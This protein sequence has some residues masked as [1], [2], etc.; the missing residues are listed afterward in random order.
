[1]ESIHYE[2]IGFAFP[3]RH[4]GRTLGAS[5]QY[6]G[7]GDM[8]ALNDQNQNIGSFS[9]HYAAYALSYG[10]ALSDRLS[11]GVAGKMIDAK[12]DDVSAQAYAA[13]VGAMYR[14]NNKITLAAT[15]VNA[16]TQLKF[17]QDAGSLPLAFKTGVAFEPDKRWKLS[18]EGVYQNNDLLSG[19]FGGEW[20]PISM[21]AIR[22]GYRTDTT[23][24]L[25]AMA[26]V[27]AGIGLELWGQ[28]FSYAY[29][30]YDDLGST[31]YFSMLLRF[32][33]RDE[34][35]RNLI[36]YRS[37]KSHRTAKELD[38]NNPDYQQLMQLLSDQDHE[39]MA[40]NPVSPGGAQ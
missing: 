21:I 2:Y 34:A 31:Q 6:L 39:F 23:K 1:L 11:L 16:G 37:I 8:T 40:H 38:S 27:S 35:K 4:E 14:L 5:A 22:A 9:S 24:E 33:Q 10:Q 15:M 3:L 13:D 25:G 12:I 19:H 17:L 26:G 18:A 29:L 28:E 32:G 7:T 30:P 20:R 36:H